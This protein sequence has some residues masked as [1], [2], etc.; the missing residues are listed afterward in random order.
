MG[1]EVAKVVKSIFEDELNLEAH[2]YRCGSKK[3]TVTR[4]PRLKIETD[5]STMEDKVI[6]GDKLINS[7]ECKGCGE[8]IYKTHH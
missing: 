2:C 1:D 3:F 4:T 6:V 8:L 5:L 7:I